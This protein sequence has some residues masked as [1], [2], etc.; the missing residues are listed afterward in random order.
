MKTLT[1]RQDKVGGFWRISLGG[2]TVGALVQPNYE[3]SLGIVPTAND[4]RATIKELHP[5][6]PINDAV[7]VVIDVNR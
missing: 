6:L 2:K 4:I 7:A 5:E 3:I 1:A